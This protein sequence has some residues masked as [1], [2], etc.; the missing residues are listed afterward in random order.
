MIHPRIVIM[1]V[2]V[3]A[4]GLFIGSAAP[5][6]AQYPPASSCQ[7]TIEERVSSELRQRLTQRISVF[8]N[9]KVLNVLNIDNSPSERYDSA[10]GLPIAEIG[11]NQPYLPLVGAAPGAWS[12][13]IQMGLEG[14]DFTWNV[15]IFQS[16]VFIT[17][18]PIHM[19]PE[20]SYY[21]TVCGARLLRVEI[22]EDY[23][24]FSEAT[25]T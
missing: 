22:P 13:T 23:D 19:F 14:T 8:V 20:G 10:T 12:G 21:L 4:L 2:T 7:T 24:P 18:F 6:A 25:G 15:R 3:V 1:I 9:Q 11:L 16:S 5:A 17:R